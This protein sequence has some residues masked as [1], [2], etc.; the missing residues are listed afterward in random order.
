M[1]FRHEGV[2]LIE[3]IIAVAIVASVVTAASLVIPNALRAN[4]NSRYRAAAMRLATA[5]MLEIQ[6]L[7]YALIPLTD[8]NTLWF[9]AGIG[10]PGCNCKDVNFATLPDDRTVWNGGGNVA[11]HVTAEQTDFYRQVCI[12]QLDRNSGTGVLDPH[13]PSINETDL[14]DEF[15]GKNVVVRV[16]W[17]VHGER[18]DVKLEYLAVR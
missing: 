13:C 1:R 12:N 17:Q 11:D 18:K 3:L 2:T 10:H 7:P 15:H 6:D 9:T 4:M 16:S 5:K 8:S 14:E